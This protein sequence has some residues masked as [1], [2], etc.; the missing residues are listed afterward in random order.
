VKKLPQY[1]RRMSSKQEEIYFSTPVEHA[2]YMVKNKWDM[3][4]VMRWLEQK[5]KPPIL[6]RQTRSDKYANYD[7]QGLVN[8]REIRIENKQMIAQKVQSPYAYMFDDLQPKTAAPDDFLGNNLN[9]HMGAQPFPPAAC[10]S[11]PT[12]SPELSSSSADDGILYDRTQTMAT[13]V[14]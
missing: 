8:H 10:M 6:L 7:A 1:S 12:T 3:K 11:T 4:E 14:I 5:L 2:M 13:I 9:P